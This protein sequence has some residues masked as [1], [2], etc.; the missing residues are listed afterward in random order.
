MHH[1]HIEFLI[2]K[3]QNQTTGQILIIFQTTPYNNIIL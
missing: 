2:L 1:L 3:Q